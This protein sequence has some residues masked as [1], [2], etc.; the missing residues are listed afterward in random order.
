MRFRVVEI[1]DPIVQAMFET[2]AILALDTT[3]YNMFHTT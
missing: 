1:E 3:R 2:Y